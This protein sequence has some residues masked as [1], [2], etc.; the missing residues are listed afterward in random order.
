M[1]VVV[2]TAGTTKKRECSYS[3]NNGSAD[4]CMW[5]HC[6]GHAVSVCYR[7]AS[8]YLITEL[9]RYKKDPQTSILETEPG[10]YQLKKGI[11]LHFFTTNVPCGFIA[12][13]EDHYLSWKI[14]FRGKPHCLKCSSVILISAYLGIQ[15]PLSHL[16]KK[17]VY[18]SSITI[19][20][21]E[22]IGELKCAEII[23]SFEDFDVL[24][25]GT[26][27]I[28][29]NNYNFHIPHVEMAEIKPKELF[30]ECFASYSRSFSYSD[31]SQT[32]ESLTEVRQA[33]GVVPVAEGNLGSHMIVSTL[34]HGIGTDG[35]EFR[36]KMKLQ[37]Q[38]ATNDFPNDIKL[39]RYKLLV[40]AQ[41]RLSLA[42]DTGKALEKL[43]NFISKEIDKR[44]TA[45][46]QSAKAVIAQL[47]EMEQCRSIT[48]EIT[49]Q[50]N[51]LL[52]SLC[53]IV[54]RIEDDCNIQA[55]KEPLPCFREK[56]ETDS[57]LVIEHL[58]SLNI[59]MKEFDNDTKSKIE[60]LTDYRAYKET[61]DDLNS[62]LEKSKSN[63]CDPQFCLDL[64]GC[65]WARSMGVI[66]KDIPGI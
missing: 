16:F 9:Y 26:D 25:Q 3:I 48:D 38:H 19:P 21:C 15:G 23:K 6:D 57:R 58:D 63:N 24:L 10:G 46:C 65:D 49:V 66:H 22:N 55:V 62:L 32:I 60:G 42:L 11:K 17:P 35:D 36:E 1:K 64:M 7:F 59:N 18:I 30:S 44:C 13:K 56:F 61:L 45:H 43:K 28:P 47:K 39:S 2:F 54:K 12:N 37:L 14:P 8:F 31:A 34:K 50:V 33:A 51:K 53:T 4:E 20:K 52:E 40:Q 27:E 5:G 29:E 41:K